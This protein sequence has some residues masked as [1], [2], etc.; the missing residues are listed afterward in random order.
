MGDPLKLGQKSFVLIHNDDNPKKY[1]FPR[2]SHI[3][4]NP[5]L[6]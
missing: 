6:R 3:A 5:I 2:L 1:I 4:K